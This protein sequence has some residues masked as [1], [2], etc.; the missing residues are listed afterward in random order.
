MG[1][2]IILNMSN[3]LFVDGSNLY[4][5]QYKLFGPDKYLDFGKFV[6]CVE[7]KLKIDFNKHQK[8]KLISLSEKIVG[9][10]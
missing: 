5:G 6:K 8:V 2:V 7:K 1:G 3:Y 9:S 10:I 4:A